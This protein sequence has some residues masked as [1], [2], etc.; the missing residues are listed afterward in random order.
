MLTEWYLSQIINLFQRLI[1][2]L[3]KFLSNFTIQEKTMTLN[4]THQNGWW[5]SIQQSWHNTLSS[6]ALLFILSTLTISCM[7]STLIEGHVL[8]HVLKMGLGIITWW[9]MTCHQTTWTMV[10]SQAQLVDMLFS[11]T[12]SQQTTWLSMWISFLQFFM[13][14]AGFTWSVIHSSPTETM[15]NRSEQ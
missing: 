12:V 15:A 8:L 10:F 4:D 11:P 9:S 6:L 5:A 1:S 14:L 13:F 7:F 2:R 3:H